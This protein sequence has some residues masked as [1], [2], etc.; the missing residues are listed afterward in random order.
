M[1][2]SNIPGVL[3][4]K[5]KTNITYWNL[6]NGGLARKSHEGEEKAVKRTNKNN[7]VV[8]EVYVPGVAGVIFDVNTHDSEF[9]KQLIVK[10][11]K[12]DW[13]HQVTIPQQSKY[14]GSFLEKLPNINLNQEIEMRPF[15]YEDE[16]S[17]KKRIGISINQLG[18][19]IGSFYHDWNNNVCTY[20]NGYPP[21]PKDWNNLKERDQKN[22]FYD[23]DEFYDAR[24]AE[25]RA[26]YAPAYDKYEQHEQVST[27]PPATPPSQ[28]KDDFLEELNE[29][30]F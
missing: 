28:S 26:K 14:F 30:P 19:K 13:T 16:K 29:P 22:Y 3:P 6:F 18:E 17:G 27:A 23:V 11:K 5:G 4:D 25:W 20:K 10:L 2:N 21:F 24:I 1:S 12:G 8:W 15:N 7:V 9:G